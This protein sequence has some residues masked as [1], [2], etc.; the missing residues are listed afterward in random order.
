VRRNAEI[1]GWHASRSTTRAWSRRILRWYLDWL[2]TQDTEALPLY[3]I[4]FAIRDNIDLAGIPA[5]A[6]CPGVRLYAGGIG[7]ARRAVDR[8]LYQ[9]PWVAER[10]SVVGELIEANGQAVL[11]VIRGVLSK[12]P[13]RQPSNCFARSTACKS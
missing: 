4:P 1:S 11:P 7:D 6:A 9:G 12:A 3:G 10:Y 13:G 2:E 5:T 8:L